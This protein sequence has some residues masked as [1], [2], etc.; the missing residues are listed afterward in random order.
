MYVEQPK[1]MLI[2]NILEILKKYSDE[3][4]RLNQKDIIDILK[5]DYDMVADRKSIRRNIL[6]LID[7]GYNIKYDKA[8]RMS[9]IKDKNG[10]YKIDPNTN[11]RVMEENNILSGFYL[12]NEFT[13]GELRLL[14]DGLIF[15]RHV[16]YNQCKELIAKLES[17]SND[18]F[19]SRVNYISRMPDDRTDNKQLFYNIEMIDEAISKNRKVSFKYMEYGTDKKMHPKKHSDGSVRE[20]VI[21]PYQMV[22][23]EGKYYLI[24]NYDKYDDI[25]NYRIDRIKDIIILDEPAKPFEKLKWA[26][27]RI[28]DLPTYMKEHVYMYSSDNVRAKLRINRPMI[29]DIIDMFGTDIRFSDEDENGVSVSVYANE[30]AVMQFAKNFAP[31]VEVLA[32]QRLRDKMKEELERA[33]KVYG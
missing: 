21:T 2:M 22:A 3:E 32:P 20:Y 7:C 25:S 27:G 19:K 6:D 24:C 28:L 4:H 33:V 9:P 17:L 12:E 30:T 11:E 18:Y 1:K 8:V 16:P 5:K 31:D 13:D 10:E 23:K 26:N 14:I 15:S 29:S